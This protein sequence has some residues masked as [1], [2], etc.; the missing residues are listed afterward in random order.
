MEDGVLSSV[1][2]TEYCVVES[3]L[4]LYQNRLLCSGI[5]F[6]VRSGLN[7]VRGLA[8]AESVKPAPFL[9]VDSSRG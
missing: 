6:Q 1:L 4:A 9:A 8:T 5:W 2:C 3:I 7:A